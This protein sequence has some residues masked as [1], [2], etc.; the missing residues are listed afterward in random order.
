MVKQIEYI[1]STDA[2]DQQAKMKF[3]SDARQGFGCS[4]LVLQGGTAFGKNARWVMIQ[5]W[6]ALTSYMVALYH[7]GVLKALNEQGLLP[8][9]ISGH[10]VG[11]M[12]AALICIHTDEELPAS[13]R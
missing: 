11:A 9:I 12:I 6:K 8:R 10:A 5:V 4:A 7:L 13:I 3:F 1:E 2:L